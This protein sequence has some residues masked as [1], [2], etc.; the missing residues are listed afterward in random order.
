MAFYILKQS[1]DSTDILPPQA[2]LLKPASTRNPMSDP[3]H[4]KKHSYS[5]PP[6]NDYKRI[7]P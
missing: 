3:L 1:H 6:V 2:G 5:H 7:V 4:Q